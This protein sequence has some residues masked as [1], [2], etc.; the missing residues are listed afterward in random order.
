[1]WSNYSLWK[2]NYLHE[3]RFVVQSPLIL[4]IDWCLGMMIKNYH[5]ERTS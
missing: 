4:K 3:I 2:Y 1:M 5:Q